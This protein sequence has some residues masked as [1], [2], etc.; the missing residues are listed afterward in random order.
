MLGEPPV[1]GGL[2]IGLAFGA[3]V[4]ASRFCLVAGV[5]NA[6]LIRDFRMLAAWLVA[7]AVAVAGT[8]WLEWR[9][10]VEVGA[11]GYRSARLDWAGALAGGLVFGLGAMLGGGCAARTVVGAGEGNVASMAT[12][13]TFGL[14]GYLG[15][16]GPI[17]PLRMALVAETSVSLPELGGGMAASL[18]VPSIALAAAVVAAAAIGAALLSRRGPDWPLLAGGAAVGMLVIAGW[19]VTGVLA[20]PAMSGTRP[21]SLSFSG[22]ISRAAA[23]LTGKSA[24]G[25][26]GLALLAGT[27]VGSFATAF[28]RG[29]LRVTRPPAGEITRAAA[30]GVLMGLG[31]SFAGGC[32]VAHGLTGLSALALKSAI[33]IVAIVAGMFV[34]LAWLTARQER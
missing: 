30:G 6:T 7:L 5:G 23:L 3:I 9:A 29:R 4:Q 11:S 18:G 31:A 17:E 15:L 12:L 32:N 34:A 14:F 8:Q 1:F 28:A 25:E 22:P 20:D 2:L 33:A 10:I 24:G 13:T 19:W 21:D 27:L 26:F 16:Y